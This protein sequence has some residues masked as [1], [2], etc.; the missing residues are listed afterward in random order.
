VPLTP[1]GIGIHEATIAGVLALFNIGGSDAMAAAL[2]DH[3]ARA[4]VIYLF[5]LISIFHL[6]TAS[7]R[8]LPGPQ[9]GS[10]V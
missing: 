6:A 4:A 7:R 5:G 10:S 1:G 3:L 9:R 2:L 8:N